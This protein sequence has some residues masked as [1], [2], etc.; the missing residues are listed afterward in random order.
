MRKQRFVAVGEQLLRAGV[1]PRHVRRILF[2]LE[3]HMDDLLEELEAHGLS[4]VEAEAQATRRLRVEAVVEAAS[5]RPELH[6]WMRRWPLPAFTIL[7]LVA[8]AAVFVGSVALLVLALELAK[9]VGV[10]LQGSHVLQQT[11]H[12]FMTGLVWVLPAGVA[13]MFCLLAS[14]RRAPLF[15]TLAGAALI[16]LL[17][18]TTNARV[19]LP[20]LVARA[21]LSAGI[22]F[23]TEALGA[24]L[25]R[26][27]CTFL[28]ALMAYVC[29]TRMRPRAV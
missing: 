28:I 2:E 21:A 23:S 15:W 17:G 9:A 26:A 10:P 11:V 25:L 12:A 27:T 5:Q 1:A 16:S 19:D 14:S 18:A 13:M 4:S 7:P 6:S 29:L 20:P 22:G 8:F 24:P 3:G